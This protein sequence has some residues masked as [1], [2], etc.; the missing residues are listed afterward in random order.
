MLKYALSGKVPNANIPLSKV[1]FTKDIFLLK[2]FCIVSASFLEIIRFI[3]SNIVGIS[4]E[5]IS[6]AIIGAIFIL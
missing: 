6:I 5:I 4:V 1:A 3:N 2:V